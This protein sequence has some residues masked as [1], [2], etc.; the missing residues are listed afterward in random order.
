[1]ETFQSDP[2]SKTA[3]SSFYR[4]ILNPSKNIVGIVWTP[5]ILNTMDIIAALRYV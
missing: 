1:M 5:D 3:L 2:I 4:P